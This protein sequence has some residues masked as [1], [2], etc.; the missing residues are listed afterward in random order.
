M[1][2]P[3]EAAP[4]RPY[5]LGAR[6]AMAEETRRRIL[7]AALALYAERWI[8]QLTLDE[9]AARAGVTVQTVLRRFGSKDGLLAAAGD[10]LERQVVQQRFAAPIGDVAGAIRNLFDHYEEVGDL[11]L[12]ALAQEGRHAPIRALTDRGR[13]LH[14]EWV[15]RA[16]APLL[17]DMPER[18]GERLLAQLV[19]VTDVYVW[20][21][22]RRD[23]G[24]DREQ[25]ELAVREL[26]DGL[27]GTSAGATT[28][29]GEHGRD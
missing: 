2:E 16:F 5:R 8:D 18:E 9:V 1:K 26:I 4:K 15:A 12:R 17:A 29:G 13:R 23:L 20:K 11:V 3:G 25:A 21:L 24:L 28:Q 19:A 14:R 6:A 10:E 22:L 27:R 7:H